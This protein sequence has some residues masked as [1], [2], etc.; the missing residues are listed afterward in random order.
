MSMGALHLVRQALLR[1]F[2]DRRVKVS[3]FL[4]VI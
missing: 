3:L 2:H 4:Q 1:F